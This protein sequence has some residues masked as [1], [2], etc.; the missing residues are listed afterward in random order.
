MLK[1]LAL[2]FG[3]VVLMMLSQLYYPLNASD[4]LRESRHFMRDKTDVFMWCAILWMTCFMF[5]RTNYND[6]STYIGMWKGADTIDVFLRNG[7]LLE[8]T[9]NPLSYLWQSFAHTYIGDF[10]TYFIPAAFLI[11]YTV[12]KYFKRYSVSA[13]FSMTVFF[14][15]GTYVMCMAAMKQCFALSILLIAVP[16]AERKQYGRF[17][18][19][20]ALAI[21][22]H[23]H[24][25]MFAILPFLFGKPWG[26]VTWCGLIAVVFT[27]LTY[28]VTLGTFMEFAQSIGA[29]VDE[30]ELFDGHQI[31]I[32]RVAVFWVPAV[33]ALIFRKRLFAHSSR[34]E[35]LAVNMSIVAAFIL[36]LGVVQAANLFAR[37]AAYFEIATAIALPWMIS[38]LL[39]K[40]YARIVTTV[41][42][43]CYF[44]YFI[45]E[46]GVSKNFDEEYRSIS[47]W[48][49]L[50][51][52]FER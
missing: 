37:M 33:L 11:S 6:T 14:S 27:I 43:V 5:L 51:G 45:Y 12:V 42:V 50:M 31:N 18:L 38:K 16:F 26:R 39:D 21:L 28:D 20:V 41:A 7:R 15:I 17:Y 23:T 13:P 3:T 10:N 44:T 49:Y 1:L 25:F 22:F 30:G 36:T 47:L 4:K 34:M 24:A 19:G 35:N 9:G 8:L 29:L 40:R 32:L 48:Q 52:L 2:Y 46:F